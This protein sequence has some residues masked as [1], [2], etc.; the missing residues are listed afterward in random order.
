MN[1]NNATI[2]EIPRV[3][4]W[5]PENPQDIIF[6]NSKG[7][8]GAPVTKSFNLGPEYQALD[9]FIMTPKK[10]YNSQVMRDH[11]CK[12]L[13]FFEKYYDPDHELA[14][15]IYRIKFMIDTTTEYN[16]LNFVHD[17]RTYL[18]NESIK[19]KVV[20]LVE[21]NYQL[22]LQYK[23]LSDN[24]KYTDTHAKI[25]L[26]M[27]IFM[28]FVIPLITHFAYVNKVPVID[29]FIMQI[30]D[31]ILYMFP[32]IDIY[33]KLYETTIS[34]VAK[35]EAKNPLWLKQDIRGKDTVTHSYASV[36]NIILNI[37]P[38]YTFDKSIIS[39]NFTSILKNTS[40][41]ILDIEYEFNYISLSSSKRDE[42]NVSDFDKYEANLVKQNEALYLQSKIN[43][44]E[45]VSRIDSLYGPF[46]EWEISFYQE[47]LKNDKGVI[48]NS[49]QKQLIFN[50]F[51]KEFHDV[52]S[53]YGINARDYIKL[54]LSAKK[55]LLQNQMIIL[56]Y[57]ISSKM[58]KIVGRK[59]V[60]KKE[61]MKL[62]SSSYYPMIV[63]KYH[64]EKI[65]KNILSMVAT[66]ISSDF[67]II[68]Y[69]NHNIDGKRIDAVPDI[70]IEEVLAYTLLI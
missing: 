16:Q 50:M 64:N 49:F 14:T 54:M 40:C 57:I 17:I 27:S 10:C 24:L 62:E 12:Y 2:A 37:M 41:Q 32:G 3:D 25:M 23:N 43:C 46:D 39:L 26:C 48:I 7:V 55:I 52:E 35:S 28:N 63:N 5:S 61:L 19:N 22:D 65:M 70:V 33:S 29:D 38:K 18:L 36:N 60:N 47:R 67:S 1:M 21:A 11:T 58:E 20:Q 45:T 13:N 42:D 56:P 44:E 69:N 66:I 6:S 30:F 68:D 51:Y 53:I 59:S 15:I 34:N 8:I 4:D 9:Y 31:L